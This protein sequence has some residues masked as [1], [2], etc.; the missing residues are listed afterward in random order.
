[1]LG[2]RADLLAIVGADPP[3]TWD[4]LSRL[5]ERIA[6]FD[7]GDDLPH[8]PE[9]VLAQPLNVR[10]AAET[11][12][13]RA[14]PA[15][16]NRAR[17][18]TLFD[19]RSMSA[20]I[21]TVPFCEALEAMIND[22]QHGTKLAQRWHPCDAMIAL[23]NGKCA[24]AIGWPCPDD[25]LKQAAMGV[26]IRMTSLPG[27]RR[28]FDPSSD[29]WSDTGGQQIQFVTHLPA[30]GRLGSVSKRSR[31]Q[32]A[33]WGLLVRLSGR[34]FG[35]T[36]C[37]ASRSSA[38]FRHSQ[39]AAAGQWMGS[40]WDAAAVDSYAQAVKKSLTAPTVVTSP[41]VLR[42]NDYRTALE[43]AVQRCLAG[44]ATATE[45]LQQVSTTWNTITDAI[46]RDLQSDAYHRSLGLQP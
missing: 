44:A 2:Y 13:A 29:E 45:A 21:G 43:Q 6:T 14:I 12:L 22:Q 24:M 34:E 39:V 9:F 5:V 26:D 33:A 32:R 8:R 18:S 15:A 1:L 36:V 3:A 20:M 27:S 37:S 23:R 25:S 28:V 35:L 30:A 38:I 19:L 31:R 42:A 41:R 40:A 17:F 16:K 10:W 7:F 4:E 46:G 11:M